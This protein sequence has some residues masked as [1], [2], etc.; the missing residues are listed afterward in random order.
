MEWNSYNFRKQISL[1][2]N[3]EYTNS[4]S[5]MLDTSTN[6]RYV[7]NQLKA[8]YVKAPLLLQY[9]T[10]PTNPDKSFHIAVGTEFGYKIDSW[11]KQK[12]EKDDYV[13][14]FKRHADYNI[15]NFKYG[16][17]V[18]AGYGR[19]TVFTNYLYTPLFDEDKGPET[20]VFPL[21]AGLSVNF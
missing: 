12:L 19:F 18:R 16:L 20:P 3:A 9:N 15:S 6:V 17:S 5:V 14:K 10:N 21:T 7:K 11:T 4:G 13:H 8:T 2:A 1:D